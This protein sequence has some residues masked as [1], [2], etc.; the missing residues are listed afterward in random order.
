M[1]ANEM[2]EMVTLHV[3]NHLHVVTRNLDE[4]N[5]CCCYPFIFLRPKMFDEAEILVDVLILDS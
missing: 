5:S 3:C 4:H 1:Q 2:T